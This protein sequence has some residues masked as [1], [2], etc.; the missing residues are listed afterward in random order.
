MNQ[1]DQFFAE[2]QGGR[3]HPVSHK[4]STSW[5]GRAH[6]KE[7][8]KI[9]SIRAGEKVYRKNADLKARIVSK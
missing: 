1:R 3:F 4:L 6:T 5:G 7:S 8:R 9:T 2:H